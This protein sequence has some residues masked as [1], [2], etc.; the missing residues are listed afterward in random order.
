MDIDFM[1]FTPELQSEPTRVSY[2]PQSLCLYI[3]FGSEMYVYRGV[4]AHINNEF[5]K[6]RSKSDYFE[7]YIKK[8]Y[9]CTRIN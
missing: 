4:P 5:L 9:P 2:D 7:R 3:S 1:N 6:A 8:F